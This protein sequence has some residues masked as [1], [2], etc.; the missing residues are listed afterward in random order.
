MSWPFSSTQPTAGVVVP[1]VTV[2]VG[3][4]VNNVDVSPV[5]IC[6]VVDDI[7]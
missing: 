5:T 3:V 6:V 4:V 7:D 1:V 2:F